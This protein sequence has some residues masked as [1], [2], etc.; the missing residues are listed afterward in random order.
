MGRTGLLGGTFNPPHIGHMIC[1]QVALE[2][3]G[4]DR[5]L[6]LPAGTPPHKKLDDDPGADVRLELCRAAVAGSEGLGVCDLEVARPGPSY[7]VE[8]L[9]ELHERDPADELTFLV[10]A[11]MALSLPSWREPQEVLRLARLAVVQRGGASR[12]DMTARLAALAPADR[13]TFVEMPRIDISST[14][15]R[16]R[17]ARGASLR[18]F[19]PDGVAAEVAARGLY[20]Q[21]ARATVR[22]G[23]PLAD[24]RT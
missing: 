20:R 15:V 4:L 22:K 2:Q 14:A 1:A 7:S 6:L 8:T 19:V 17:A 10:G 13:V 12:A 24:D 11:D 9:R 21:G 5:V 16:A 18:F 3:L 23:E